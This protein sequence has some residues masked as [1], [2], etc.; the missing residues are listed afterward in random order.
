MTADGSVIVDQIDAHVLEE[1]PPNS[2]DE[3]RSYQ[4]EYD[5][6]DSDV[7]VIEVNNEGNQYCIDQFF[8]L[9]FEFCRYLLLVD[10][11]LNYAVLSH[12]ESF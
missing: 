10:R 12:P 4:S 8:H 6:E 11:M 5:V 7:D 9:L 2:D 3:E 1:E